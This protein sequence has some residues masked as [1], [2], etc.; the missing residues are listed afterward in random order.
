MFILCHFE[1]LLRS[2]E[3]H[4]GLIVH[5]HFVQ[6]MNI[7]QRLALWRIGHVFVSTCIRDGL[8]LMPIEYILAHQYSD[9][10]VLILSEF[11]GSSRVING[12]LRINPLNP[13][14]VRKEMKRNVSPFLF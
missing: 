1:I 12:A 5:L 9:P 11:A 2:E 13:D 10:G 8:N 7:H 6:Q 3:H 4:P 14:E